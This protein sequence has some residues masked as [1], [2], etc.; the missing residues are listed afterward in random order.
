M[1]KGDGLVLSADIWTSRRGHSFFGIVASFINVTFRGHAVLLSCNHLQGHHNADR[2]YQMYES[3]LKYWN[4]E[5]RVIR[6]VTDSASNIVKA[7]K[8]LPVTEEEDE[9]IDEG[10]AGASSSSAEHEEEDGPP[11]LSQIEV[12]QIATN[13][14]NMIN[15]YFTVSSLHLRCPIHMLQLPIKDA[16]NEHD[17]NNRL[18]VKVGNVVR[19][20]RKSTLS[21][22]QTDHLGV[23]PAS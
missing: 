3:V 23:R 5:G 4:V 16:V 18:L 9:L 11:A 19:S 20:V 22:E 12:E 13:V 15:Q 2:I 7:F 8:L 1:K 21:T 14:E 17:S 10:I 6:V